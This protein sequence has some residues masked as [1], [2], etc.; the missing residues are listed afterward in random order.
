M[1]IVQRQYRIIHRVP[2]LSRVSY[3]KSPSVERAKSLRAASSRFQAHNHSLESWTTKNGGDRAEAFTRPPDRCVSSLLYSSPMRLCHPILE[4]R[5]S[6][7]TYE[8]LT[9][10]CLP[11]R[12]QQKKREK[13][14]DHDKKAAKRKVMMSI[15]G[16]LV[17]GESLILD[18]RGLPQ[19]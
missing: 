14:R 8:N 4:S 19:R 7:I 1:N 12:E 13:K 16:S 15:T 3:S 2:A 6:A 11:P 5:A 18:C 9:P 10:G 17:A